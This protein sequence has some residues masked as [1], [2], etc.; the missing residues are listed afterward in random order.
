MMSDGIFFDTRTEAQAE[1]D[2]L[3]LEER[4][5]F[6]EPYFTSDKWLLIRSFARFRFPQVLAFST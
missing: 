5:W 6:W 3:N 1:A 4:L 2:R